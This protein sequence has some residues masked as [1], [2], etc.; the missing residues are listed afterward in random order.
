MSV[1]V[2][3]KERSG[4]AGP[5]KEEEGGRQQL[6]SLLPKVGRDT[7]GDGLEGIHWGRLRGLSRVAT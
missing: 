5:T 6:F 4:G 3:R 2:K 7:S 1:V